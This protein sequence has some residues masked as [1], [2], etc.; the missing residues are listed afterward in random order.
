MTTI[1]LHSSYRLSFYTLSGS[2]GSLFVILIMG[3]SLEILEQYEPP[4]EV[5][6]EEGE[7]EIK[8]ER[9]GFY[10]PVSLKRTR[11]M[12]SYKYIGK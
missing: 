8:D 1:I 11:K 12:L 3:N 4:E 2:L 7:V 10:P 9:V 6:S 5:D